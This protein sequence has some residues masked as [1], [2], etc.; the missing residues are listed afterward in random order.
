MEFDDS[1]AEGVESRA[2]VTMGP[3]PKAQVTTSVSV[4]AKISVNK[5]LNCMIRIPRCRASHKSAQ[6]GKIPVLR[7]RNNAYRNCADAI[8]GSN[9]VV[10]S[11]LMVDKRYSGWKLNGDIERLN[12][13][14]RTRRH[15]LTGSSVTLLICR[16]QTCRVRVAH[17]V[18]D[19]QT[20]DRV[21]H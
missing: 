8:D 1:D 9:V 21:L 18:R 6:P 20:S 7:I 10:D 5:R 11:R 13:L 3:H 4:V 14:V 2:M 16:H 15:V 12:R 17:A 19:P